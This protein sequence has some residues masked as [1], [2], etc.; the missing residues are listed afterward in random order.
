MFV[1]EDKR[2]LVGVPVIMILCGVGGGPSIGATPQMRFVVDKADRLTT[3]RWFSK[4]A[5]G[6]VGP[7][8]PLTTRFLTTRFH[9]VAV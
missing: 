9:V 1:M 7:V 8:S 2:A 3:C 4:L 6:V 5:T